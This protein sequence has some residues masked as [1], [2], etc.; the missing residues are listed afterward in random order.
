MVVAG[1][2]DLRDATLMFSGGAG[3]VAP[4]QVMLLIDHTSS[5]PTVMSTK[6][7]NGGGIE[8]GD[9]H[10]RVFYIGGDA[11]DR[12]LAGPIDGTGSLVKQ[13]SGVLTMPRTT[14]NSYSGGTT[15]RGGVLSLGSGGASDSSSV[16]AL[17]SGTIT[18]S[19]GGQLRLWISD[20]GAYS[21]PNNVSL[22]GGAV[23]VERGVYDLAGGVSLSTAGQAGTLLIDRGAVTVAGG[24]TVDTVRVGLF[25]DAV[26]N[27]GSA[28]LT[29]S[30]GAVSIGTGAT[31]N[32]FDVARR[33]A[34]NGSVD[35]FSALADFT[36]ASSVTINVD[37][38][39]VATLNDAATSGASG[40]AT[41]ELRLSAAGANM[42]TAN[43]IV[44]SHSKDASLVGATSRLTLGNATNTLN[45]D[46]ITIGGWQGNA[47]LA[48][49]AQNPGVGTLTL[50]GKN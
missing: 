6:P 46:S 43:S 3:S 37:Q 44:V 38:L 21:L 12:Q 29:V 5:S 42:V 17:G 7:V 25:S 31:G 32:H 27:S 48:F 13:G 45:A 2:L 39:R 19:D 22:A 40:V 15:I 10:Y 1:A 36:N 8:I 24:L 41:G 28:T 9:N 18:V 14:P 23:H 50:Q 47:V 26:S 34:N 35:A 4:L 11:N 49:A 33:E 20:T 16:G 30:G